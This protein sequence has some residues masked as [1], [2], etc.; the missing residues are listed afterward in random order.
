MST[1]FAQARR[2]LVTIAVAGAALPGIAASQTQQDL[3]AAV[4][5]R[6]NVH[7]SVDEIT[8]QIHTRVGDRL[9]TRATA[10]R[11]RRD[12]HRIVSLG[13]FDDVMTAYQST[14]E[15]VVLY[16]LVEERPIIRDIVFEGA[17]RFKD[18]KLKDEIGWDDSK[19]NFYSPRNVAD[20]TLAVSRFYQAQ[21]YPAT[22]VTHVVEEKSDHEVVVNI[23]I[24]E[25]KQWRIERIEFEG[26]EKFDDKKL[27]KQMRTRARSFWFFRSKYDEGKFN[28]DLASLRR[29]LGNEGHLDAQVA[30]GE[31]EE[32][33]KGLILK[34]KVEEGP[35]YTA[36]P[37]QLRGNTLF[38]DTEIASV[39]ETATGEVFREASYLLDDRRRIQELYEAQGYLEASVRTDIVE[40]DPEKAVARPS[41]EIYEGSRVR[42]GHVI[43]RGVANTGEV[44]DGQAVYSDTDLKTKRYVIRREIKLAQ[45][46]VFDW[47]KVKEADRQLRRLGYFKAIGF[48]D[49]R[50]AQARQRGLLLEPGFAPPIATDD[51]EV[52]DLLLEVEEVRA[53]SIGFGAGYSTRSGG[54]FFINLEEPNLYGRGQRLSIGAMAGDRANS[55]RIALT[56]P[57]FRQSEYSLTWDVYYNSRDAF[58]GRKFDEERYGL[59]LR[60]GRPLWP[61][62]RVYADLR[63]ES[64]DIDLLSAGRFVYTRVPEVWPT[65][66]TDTLSIGGGIVHDTRDSLE[67]PTEGHLIRWDNKLG[68]PGGDNEY[69]KSAVDADF[70]WPVSRQFVLAYRGTVGVAAGYGDTD[71]VP[72]FERFFAGGASSVRGFEEDAIGP[73]DVFFVDDIQNPRYGVQ[74]NDKVFI[75]GET[76]WINSLELRYPLTEIIE[77]LMFVDAGSVWEDAFEIDPSELRVGAGVGLRVKLPIGATAGL[78]FGIPLR[79]LD[80]DETRTVHF[81]FAQSFR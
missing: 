42:L 64:I 79:E 71:E 41:I 4:E 66:R 22:Q 2:W 73:Y 68:T 12:M 8:A 26:N 60:L 7:V 14:P 65:E 43:I 38:S 20:Y 32:A 36:L 46:D 52:Y 78:D 55:F 18:K 50:Y 76:I 33:E 19:R 29:F 27:I 59:G 34:I 72:I 58:G 44:V 57:Y 13:F 70:Y 67:R 40:R 24:I 77:G 23:R 62:T 1:A 69:F 3:I 49:P 47:T 31:F 16:Y 54:S 9:G 21:G 25:G 81:R 11:I 28:S 61:D 37:P 5:V 53:G 45:G 39:V 10:M 48:T 15:G 51:P 75:G 80:E 63:Y 30:K 35:Q 56:E 17:E 6:G 74:D